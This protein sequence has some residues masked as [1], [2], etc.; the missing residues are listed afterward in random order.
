MA[1]LTT[2]GGKFSFDDRLLEHLKVVIS[3]KLRLHESFT[4]SWRYTPASGSGER[5]L[6]LSSGTQL[7]FRFTNVRPVTL[8]TRWLAA[9][10]EAAH[11]TGGLHVEEVPEPLDEKPRVGT[12]GVGPSPRP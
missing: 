5:S 3:R 7:H 11:E 6:W 12:R 4:M 1:T 10:T 2:D 9:L 8:N